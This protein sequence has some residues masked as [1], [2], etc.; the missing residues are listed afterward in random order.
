MYAMTRLTF[1]IRRRVISTRDIGTARAGTCGRVASDGFYVS[2]NSQH[3]LRPERRS[4]FQTV[5]STRDQEM[6]CQIEAL[7]SKRWL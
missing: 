7:T 6:R 1:P 4:Q 2:V 5:V 3:C